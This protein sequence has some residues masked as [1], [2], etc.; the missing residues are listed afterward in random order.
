MAPQPNQER[1]I[2]ICAKRY[3][4]YS[5]VEAR[6]TLEFTNQQ[7]ETD[8]QFYDTFRSHVEAFEH[9]GGT[10]GNDDDLLDELR[11]EIDTE[12]P[13]DIPDVSSATAAQF[14]T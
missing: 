11:D 9:F 10:I 8:E 2:Q 7:K 4:F 5:L 12:H 6:A 13:G 3:I 14:K 1:D